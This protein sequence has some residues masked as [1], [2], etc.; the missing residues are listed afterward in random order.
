[1]CLMQPDGSKFNV[2]YVY[3]RT[4]EGPGF[5]GTWESTSEKVNSVFELQ[6][7]PYESDG[8]AFIIPSEGT[9]KNLKFD[10]KDYAYETPKCE[11]KV[12]IFNTP[13][14]RAH[15]GSDRQG[16]WQARGHSGGQ[17]FS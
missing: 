4:A 16:R 13:S 17:A 5:A 7:E 3:K 14:G 8:L 15:P 2:Y 11:R 6:I 9:V 1:M 12:C 10:G